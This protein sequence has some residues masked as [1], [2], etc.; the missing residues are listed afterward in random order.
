VSVCVLR[1]GPAASKRLAAD[2]VLRGEI[3]SRANTVVR[4]YWVYN[5]IHT[6]IITSC[7]RRDS[8]LI[9]TGGRPLS[10]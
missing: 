5:V 3:L 7:N 1:F 8:N 4:V 9:L 6:L 10:L 2:I